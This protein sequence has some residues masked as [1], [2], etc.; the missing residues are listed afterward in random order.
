[1]EQLY[2]SPKY[3]EAKTSRGYTYRYYFT[4]PA[5]SSKPTLLFVHGFP[6]YS[7]HW[8]HQIAFFEAEGFGLVVPDMLGYGGTSVPTQVEAFGH[9]L[10]AK[11]LVEILDAE[12]LKSN[13]IA[14]GHDWGSITVSRLANLYQDRFLGFVFIAVG[15]AAPNTSFS[16]EQIKAAWN[17]VAGYESIGYWSFFS[18]PEAEGLIKK[19]A[20]SFSDILWAKDPAAYKWAFCPSG[21]LQKFLETDSSV[22]RATYISN[23]DIKATEEIHFKKGFSG[24][25]AY[26]KLETSGLGLEDSKSIPVENYTIAKPVLFIAAAQDAVAIPV[27]MEQSLH[28]YC[29]NSSQKTVVTGHWAFLEAADEVNS[30]IHDWAKKL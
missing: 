15:Y 21:S 17:Q 3:K 4:K 23:E 13:V 27:L 30:L 7:A 18:S 1:M 28:K 26:Y 10:Q 24:P 19:H 2:N 20:K 14:I 29:T 9:S 6:S 11:D 25:L 16:Y 8:I 5:V 12:D 22:P